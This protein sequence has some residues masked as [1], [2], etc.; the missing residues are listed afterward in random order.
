MKNIMYHV[1]G[2]IT[3]NRLKSITDAGIENFGKFGHLTHSG[4]LFKATDLEKILEV[5]N[6]IIVKEARLDSY[7]SIT[8]IKIGRRS[9][10]STLYIYY[11]TKNVPSFILN[12]LEDLSDK[13]S[14]TIHMFDSRLRSIPTN[15]TD[16]FIIS[17]NILDIRSG[18]IEFGY[19][20]LGT[21]LYIN[22]RIVGEIIDNI[23]FIYKDKLSIFDTIEESFNSDCYILDQ[24]CNIFINKIEPEE[25]SIDKISKELQETFKSSYY[26]EYTNTLDNHIFKSCI[27]DQLTKLTTQLKNGLELESVKLKSLE[28]LILDKSNSLISGILNDIKKLKDVSK[29]YV[30]NGFIYVHTYNILAYNS[31]TLLSHAIGRLIIKLPLDDVSSPIKILNISNIISLNTYN[32]PHV[33]PDGHMCYGNIAESITQ[34][35]IDQNYFATISLVLSIIKNPNMED[36]GGGWVYKFPVINKQEEKKYK[37]ET[38]QKEMNN[39]ISV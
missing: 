34:S 39:D 10:F 23:V 37:E 20:G 19:A 3:K 22:T 15:N 30:S 29:V 25:Q 11:D 2:G 35:R 28:S 5:T 38:I 6:S 13:L 32:A 24:I 31:K 18:S 33:Y 4:I 7:T 17:G 21:P 14:T 8:Y 27:L 1:V 16:I 9:T 36:G 12:D 26:I